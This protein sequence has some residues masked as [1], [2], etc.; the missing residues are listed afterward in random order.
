M[1]C[2]APISPVRHSGRFALPALFT[3]PML[4]NRLAG[5]LQRVNGA[6]DWV[7]CLARAVAA[8]ARAAR[9]FRGKTP[10]HPSPLCLIH[11]NT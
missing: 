7:C 9:Q 8:A 6:Q 1:S 11:R 5:P 4:C 3:A 10:R 2:P